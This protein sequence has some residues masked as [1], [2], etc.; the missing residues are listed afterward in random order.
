MHIHCEVPLPCQLEGFH[1][2]AGT[3][4]ASLVSALLSALSPPVALSACC[5]TLCIM[6]PPVQ[7]L[8]T[9]PSLT[10]QP[11]RFFVAGVCLKLKYKYI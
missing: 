7:L 9:L 10:F 3:L 5:R 6:G 1:A 11:T 2:L 8:I 4:L